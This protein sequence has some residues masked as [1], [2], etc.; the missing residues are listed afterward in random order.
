MSKSD[1]SKI[2]TIRLTTA[3]KR[4]ARALSLRLGCRL[5]CG[6]VAYSLKWL[7]HERAKIEKVPLEK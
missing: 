7:L 2:T 1:D 4:Y 6:S 3:E 5:D